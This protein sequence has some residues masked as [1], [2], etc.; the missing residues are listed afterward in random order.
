MGDYYRVP[1]DA[2]SLQYELYYE[3][4]DQ[5]EAEFDDYTSANTEQMDVEQTQRLLLDLPQVRELVKQAGRPV[6]ALT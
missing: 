2:R 1:L 4:G 3:Q 5:L 6:P